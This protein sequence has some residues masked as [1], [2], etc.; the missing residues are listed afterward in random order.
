MVKVTSLFFLVYFRHNFDEAEQFKFFK[1]TG[2]K[3]FN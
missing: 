1:S 2:G 3:W